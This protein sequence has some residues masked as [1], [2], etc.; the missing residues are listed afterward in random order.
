MRDCYV[1]F[2]RANAAF[3]RRDR[4]TETSARTRAAPAMGVCATRCAPRSAPQA[5]DPAVAPWRPIPTP[6]RDEAPFR[7][8]RKGTSRGAESD[9]VAVQADERVPL[10]PGLA[11]VAVVVVYDE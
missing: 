9:A 7:L 6:S 11:L 1:T 4:A 2:S 3:G 8:A 5:G 10:D